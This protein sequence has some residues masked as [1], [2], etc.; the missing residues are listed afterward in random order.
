MFCSQE[1]SGFLVLAFLKTVFHYKTA[2]KMPEPLENRCG[3]G[4]AHGVF[5]TTVFVERNGPKK[6]DPQK[7][8]GL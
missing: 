3:C 1:G 8:A 5:E 4:P 2:A 7:S 6:N